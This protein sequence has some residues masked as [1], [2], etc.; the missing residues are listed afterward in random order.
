MF[1]TDLDQITVNG[2]SYNDNVLGNNMHTIRTQNVHKVDNPYKNMIP[3]RFIKEYSLS[4]Y[5]ANIIVS[6]KATSEY[7]EDV[8]KNRNPI[9]E[10]F[11]KLFPNLFV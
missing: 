2:L 8:V 10:A 6:D 3:E 5:D 7:F 4:S 9:K 11:S 1:A